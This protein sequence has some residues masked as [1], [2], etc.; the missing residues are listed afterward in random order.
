MEFNR[1]AFSK[2][3][4]SRNYFLKDVYYLSEKGETAIKR[5]LMLTEYLEILQSK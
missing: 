5:F 3:N 1:H 4:V 2:K